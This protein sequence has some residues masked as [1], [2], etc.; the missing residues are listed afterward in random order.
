MRFSMDEA[1]GLGAFG[2]QSFSNML[3]LAPISLIVAGILV[4][5][6]Q[7]GAPITVSSILGIVVYCL[8]LVVIFLYPLLGAIRSMSKLKKMELAKVSAFYVMAYEKFINE[9]NNEQDMQ[10]I[11][12]Y[13]E[14]MIAA[15]EVFAGILRQPTVPYSSRLAGALAAVLGPIF[16]GLGALLFG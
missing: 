14:T 7:D 15:E 16:G 5:T 10:Q 8:L 6:S 13:S 1:G 9:M 2:I 4:Q 3:V 11:Q 12:T